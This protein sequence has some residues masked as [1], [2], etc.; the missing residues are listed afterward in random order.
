MC[1]SLHLKAKKI[2]K[3]AREIKKKQKRKFN[4]KNERELLSDIIII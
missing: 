3:R 4:C 2:L 1:V